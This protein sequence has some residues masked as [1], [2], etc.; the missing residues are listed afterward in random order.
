MTQGKEIRT[1]STHRVKDYRK[2]NT[3]CT[4]LRHL[5][6]ISDHHF[7]S[8]PTWARILLCSRNFI[9]VYYHLTPAT[10]EIK[11]YSE[12]SG[13]QVQVCLINVYTRQW[14]IIIKG[15]C[16]M[17]VTSNIVTSNIV[18]SRVAINCVC[19]SLSNFSQLV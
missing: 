3:N 13:V 10:C 1:H 16:Q 11:I 7:F 2:P 15:I 8:A 19:K 9:A 4:F 12:H 6:F 14:I 5:G 17:F 18:T